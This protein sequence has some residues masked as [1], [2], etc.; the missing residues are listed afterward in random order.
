MTFPAS[1][2]TRLIEWTLLW[3]LL[4]LVLLLHL[5]L[6]L[7]A[8]IAKLTPFAGAWALVTAILAVYLVTRPISISV[9]GGTIWSV[10]SRVVL[11]LISS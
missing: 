8:A 11:Q 3:I 2:T 6:L 9:K 5:L 4:L 10:A 1:Q 7:T